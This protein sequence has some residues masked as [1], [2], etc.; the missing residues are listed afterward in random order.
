MPVCRSPHCLACLGSICAC[1]L[2]RSRTMKSLPRPCILVK[3]SSMVLLRQ[4]A[5]ASE[6]L[7]YRLTATHFK[8]LITVHQHFGGAAAGVVVGTHDKPIG[9][10]RMHG[11]QVTF[12]QGKLTLLGQEIAGLAD[13][14]DDVVGTRSGIARA[15]GGD[16]HPSLV[17]RR[18]DQAVHGWV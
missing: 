6:Q 3:R 18:A 8:C 7:G 13:R 5:F 17:K 15:H 11:Q 10:S 16:V 1:W 9:A 12:F 14:A 2:T 4:Q